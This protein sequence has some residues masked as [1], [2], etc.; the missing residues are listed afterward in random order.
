MPSRF[1]NY[2]VRYYIWCN[3]GSLLLLFIA[4]AFRVTAGG[5]S[6]RLRIPLPI[7]EALSTSC[8]SC[9]RE[10]PWRRLPAQG[11]LWRFI[12]RNQTKLWEHVLLKRMI[13]A[14][15]FWWTVRP[16]VVRWMINIWIF[17]SC[18]R[19]A[20]VNVLRLILYSKPKWTIIFFTFFP[21]WYKYWPSAMQFVVCGSLWTCIK[22]LE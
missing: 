5:R 14:S 7:Y 20:S 8:D 21:V 4:V 1:N 17:I 22:L 13:L 12:S 16:L 15:V 10:Y 3:G 9:V 18:M 19:R 2:Q 6:R 11:R